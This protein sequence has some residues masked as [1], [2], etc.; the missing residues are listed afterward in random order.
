MEKIKNRD[1]YLKNFQKFFQSVKLDG[2]FK[3]KLR[4]HK[5]FSDYMPIVEVFHSY[6]HHFYSFFTFIF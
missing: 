2:N 1:D 3:K 5:Y 6:K 4:E